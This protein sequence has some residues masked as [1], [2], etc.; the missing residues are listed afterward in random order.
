MAACWR[1]ARLTRSHAIRA[2]GR[3]ISGSRSMRDLLV[4][5]RFSAGYGEAVVLSQISL[6]VAD[7]EALAVLG[8]NGMGKTT[9]IN[10]IVGVTRYRGGT[11]RLDGR[12][13]T[14]LRPEQRAHAGIGWVP[15]ERNIFKSLT[16]HENL[17]AV[18]R[19]GR[20]TPEAVYEL[21]PRL[22]ARRHNLGSQPSGGQQP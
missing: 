9:L 12:D 17:T 2:C 5:D 3:P 21:F 18:A 7:G 19:P 4:L 15:Q 10:S 20:W 14:A 6:A 1:R 22:A 16:V 8:R 11:I 13:I